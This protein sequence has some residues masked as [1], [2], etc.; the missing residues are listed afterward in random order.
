[1]GSM[2]LM[3]QNTT[4]RVYGARV[5]SYCVLC[6]K[7]I[8]VRVVLSWLPAISRQAV[9]GRPYLWDW[10][11][12]C[13]YLQARLLEIDCNKYLL[14]AKS[15]VWRLLRDLLFWKVHLY[16]QSLRRVSSSQEHRHF[17]G[18][19][20]SVPFHGCKLLDNTQWRHN[21][22]DC[23]SNH[24]RDDCLLSRLLGADQ[25]M[26]QRS[27]SLAFVRGIHYWPVNSHTKGLYC[28]KYFHMMRPSWNTNMISSV[29]KCC[30]I[31]IA[32]FASVTTLCE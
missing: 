21:E 3:C 15:T 5:K 6:S 28:G 10:S 18:M 16:A 26:H 7:H 29:T 23:V 2:L 8:A 22:C 14:T 9:R 24:R 4:M 12:L 1:M 30:A 31:T 11:I 32:L 13:D 25:R 19:L 20:V 17:R 27:A